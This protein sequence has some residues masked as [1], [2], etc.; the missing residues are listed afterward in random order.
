MKIEES[1]ELSSLTTF[2]VASTAAHYTKVTTES[3]LIE[4]LHFADTLGLRAQILGGG[5]NLLFKDDFS[6]LI[7]HI[8]NTGIL[9]LKG[10]HGQNPRVIVS[11]GENWHSLVTSAVKKGFYGLENLA[12]IP[13]TV[14]AA[15]IQNI[16]AY[17]AEIKD[18]I[19][20]VKVFDLLKQKWRIL[21]AKECEF[22]YRDSLF[23]RLEINPYIIW[24]VTLE[25]ETSWIPNLA[26]K[27]LFDVFSKKEPTAN[28]IFIEV[29]KIRR[30]KLPD[31]LVIGNAGSFFKNPLISTDKFEELKIRFPYLKCYSTEY[32]DLVKVSAAWLLD[33]AGW[34]GKKRGS[35]AVYD[36]HALI[37]VNNGGATGKDILLLAQDMRDSILTTYGITLEPEVK[38]I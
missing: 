6:G 33:E 13:G 16:G 28:E 29:C 10:E 17:G 32:S 19:I 35:A 21:T 25:L 37:L 2:G 38:I 12:L 20:E 15:P 1:R 9:W 3:E 34:K 26:H 30:K 18:Y 5:S 27:D 8:A 23:K 14:G 22:A 31:P 11:A 4:A 7:I 24:S 36:H